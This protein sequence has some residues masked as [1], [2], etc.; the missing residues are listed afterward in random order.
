MRTYA[1]YLATMTVKTLNVIARDLQLKGYSKLRKAALVEI[2]DNAIVTDCV[3]R[4]DDFRH[5]AQFGVWPSEVKILDVNN[6]ADLDAIAQI[7]AT[8]AEPADS[9]P[10][11]GVAGTSFGELRSL[12]RKAPESAVEAPAEQEADED[13]LDDLKYAYSAMRAT[14]RKATGQMQVKIG[15]RLRTLGAKIRAYGVN[16]QYV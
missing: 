14:F 16:P 13:S 12:W 8:V 3:D 4:S 1:E 15:I 10:V 2:I 11:A 9:E 5:F 6:E 7:M